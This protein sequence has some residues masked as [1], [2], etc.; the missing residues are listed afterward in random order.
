MLQESGDHHPKDALKNPSNDSFSPGLFFFV[1]NLLKSHEICTRTFTLQES[2]ISCMEKLPL[3]V[4]YFVLNIDW[5]A[6]FATTFVRTI[7]YQKSSSQ[8]A[9]AG[10]TSPC[11]HLR[12]LPCIPTTQTSQKNLTPGTQTHPTEQNFPRLWDFAR[13]ICALH[14]FRHRNPIPQNNKHNCHRQTQGTLHLPSL[15][16]RPQC[17]GSSRLFHGSTQ[18]QLQIQRKFVRLGS[19]QPNHQSP[20]EP[21]LNFLGPKAS[22]DVG[23]CQGSIRT[24]L[25]HFGRQIGRVRET[26][27]C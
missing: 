14:P 21:C 1:G 26:W 15:W 17:A 3:F 9:M 7:S 12:G 10:K 24:R 8:Q 19:K 27:I 6:I 4:V 2:N 13:H 22:R 5:L 25:Q 11:A 16:K 20:K 23:Y 18:I